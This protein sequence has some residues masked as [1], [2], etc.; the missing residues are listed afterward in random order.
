ME[1][2][3]GVGV[4]NRYAL[5]MAGGGED[6]GTDGLIAAAAAKTANKE[7]KEKIQP[8]NAM[9]SGVKTSAPVT[10]KPKT[11]T[12][13]PVNQVKKE[14]SKGPRKDGNNNPG[15]KSTDSPS[16]APVGQ[17]VKKTRREGPSKKPVGPSDPSSAVSSQQSSQPKRGILIDLHGY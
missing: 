16:T 1:A 3:Y 9:N 6:D 7:N 4:V 8:K 13:Q 2:K 10:Q 15:K 14:P 5:L 12:S 11:S 17:S